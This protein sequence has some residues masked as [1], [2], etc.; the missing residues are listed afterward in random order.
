LPVQYADYAVWQ[1]Q[2]LQGEVLE[3]QVAYWREQLSGIP[4]ISGLPTDKPRPAIQSYRGDVLLW[5]LDAE[6]SNQ[7]RKLSRD[8]SATLFMTL[9][10]AL[11]V[12][13]SRHSGERELVIGAP[14]AGRMQVATEK[15]IGF[16]VNTLVLRVDL[17]GDP[18]FSELLERVRETT[19]GAYTHQEIP[20]EKLVEELR[21]E[22]SL[23]HTPLFQVMLEM[24]NT[25][26]APPQLP[27][28]TLS[29][30]SAAADTAKFDLEF[31]LADDGKSALAGVVNYSTDLYY[32]E[33]IRSLTARWQQLLASVVA[34]PH[35]PIS[36]LELLPDDERA[37]LDEWNLT[38]ANYPAQHCFQE[39]FETQAARTPEA[40]AAVFENERISYHELNARANKVAWALIDKHVDP[41]ALVALLME[42][43]P[44]FAAAMLGVFKAGAAYLPLDPLHP[45]RRVQQVLDQSRPGVLLADKQFE[46]ILLQAMHDW[47]ADDPPQVMF[48]EDLLQQDLAT[49]NPP[50]AATPANLAY[51]IYTSGSTG[52]PKGAMVEHRGM[53]NHLF[54]KVEELTLTERDTVAQTASQSFDISIWQLLSPLLV[55]GCTHIMASD[56]THDPLRLLDEVER[57]EVSI[58]ELVP[59][60]LRATL[61]NM[62][63]VGDTRRL[64]SLRCLLLTGEALRPDLCRQWLNQYP[65]IPLLNAYGPTECSDDVTH[66]R[67]TLPPGEAEFHVAI[68]RPIGNLRTYILDRQ[69]QRVPIGVK[70]ELFVAGVGVGRGYLNDQVQ[71]AEAF[72]PDPFGTEA[73]ARLYR[74]GDLARYRTDGAIEYLGRRDEQV[75]VRGFRIELTEIEATLN[76]HQQISESVVMAVS[77]GSAGSHLVAY[78]VAPENLENGAPQEFLRERLPDYM[79][80]AAFIRL[81]QMPLTPNGKIDRRALPAPAPEL[82]ERPS[83][84]VAPETDIEKAQAELWAQLLKLDRVGVEDNFFELGGHSLA[85]TQLATRIAANFGVELTLAEF[86]AA[87]T[88]RA[89]SQ[90]IEAALLQQT[91]A[92]ELDR[93]LSELEAMG[94]VEVQN[95]TIDNARKQSA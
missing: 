76:L 6:L 47:T 67:I 21:P 75:K 13:L 77:N 19:L 16:F 91:S 32:A 36:Q 44:N 73:G 78:F 68:G 43:T 60:L 56:I 3:Q 34:D 89:V 8:E 26:E 65:H 35:Q 50:V 10:A 57:G 37:Q 25:D 17:S 80:P 62:A 9:L 45:V 40:V 20:F 23:G 84:Y 33:T 95:L 24:R 64:P 27:G 15:L 88:V 53:L 87:P 39:L 48:V 93:M 58:L 51:V 86:F 7:L 29:G 79:I 66:Q 30:L 59:S 12:L 52:Q 42:R 49:T 22:R 83:L 82:L 74:T 55:G 1:R 46:P 63:I 94:D 54:A 85:A 81:Q 5:Q 69:Q 31:S 38:A 61:E 4:T 90:K 72:V 28:L 2:W 11:A 14:I 92:D 18:S 71:T 70:G 41:E